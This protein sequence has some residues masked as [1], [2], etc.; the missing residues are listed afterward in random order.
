MIQ[1]GRHNLDENDF[2]AVL[3]VLKGDWLS[4]G[5]EVSKFEENLSKHTGAPTVVVSSGTAALHCAYQALDLKPGD[6]VITTPLT[7]VATQAAAILSGGKIVFAD[8][9]PDTGNLDPKEALRHIGARTVAIT[10]VDYAGHPGYLN[11]LREI[12]DS[13]NLILIEDAAHSIE[14]K[15]EGRKV[16]Q[17]ADL[18]T[19]SFFP[20]KNIT[21]GEGGAVSSPNPDLL[22]KVRQFARQGLVR[23]S[24]KFLIT[25]QGPWH[26][27]VHRFGLN[28]RLPDILCALGNSQLSRIAIFKELRNQI[29]DFYTEQFS[30]LPM[31]KLPKLCSEAEP[32]WHL[33]PIRVDPKIRT[34]MFEFLRNSG[35]GVQVNYI[36]AYWHPAFDP[37]EYPRGL[38]PVAESYYESEISLPIHPGLTSDE[39]NFVSTKVRE[40]LINS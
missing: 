30:D 3:N 8:V 18:T 5:P 27:E 2:D 7:F 39:L 20:T 12:A 34:K 37:I 36:P 28:Y 32:M 29:F 40:F 13:R 31:I 25:D 10:T 16:G 11:E 21:S 14:S 4:T 19:F 22:E 23:E 24:D 6:E 35:I 1:S 38:C 15:Y 9:D 17:I 33:Y 26:Q